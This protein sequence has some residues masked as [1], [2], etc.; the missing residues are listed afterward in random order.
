MSPFHRLDVR[1][2][3]GWF[4]PLA[5]RLMDRISPLMLGAYLTEVWTLG[6]AYF[7]AIDWLH[8]GSVWS[9]LLLPLF[10][11]SGWVL[12]WRILRTERKLRVGYV[13]PLRAAW[14][15]MRSGMVVV[16]ALTLSHDLIVLGWVAGAQAAFLH[17]AVLSALYFGSCQK[18]PPAARQEERLPALPQAT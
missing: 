2:L 7:L 13:N 5:N 4:Q 16:C 17:A 6:G 14:R 9:L 10:L 18:M 1:L 3:D 11:L 8:K 12:R 15:N